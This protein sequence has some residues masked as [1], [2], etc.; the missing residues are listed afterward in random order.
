MLVV[1]VVPFV[2]P[3]LYFGFGR[4]PIPRPLRLVF[5]LGA[6]VVCLAFVALGALIS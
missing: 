1:L 6:V 2:G 3:L 4:S 5:T